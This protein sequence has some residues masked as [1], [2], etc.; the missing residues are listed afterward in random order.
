MWSRL[1]F[2]SLADFLF[3][4]FLV[5]MF[6][7]G[8]GWKALL[9]D[10]DTGWHIRTGQYILERGKVPLGDIFSFTKFGEQWFAWEW[11]SDVIFATLHQYWGLKG[12]VLLAGVVLASAA[13]LVFQHMIWRGANLFVSLLLTLLAMGAATVHYLARPHIFTLLL[14]V[15]SM[16][17]V[18]RDRRQQD[19]WVWVLVPMTIVWANLHGG[20]LSVV[21]CIGMVGAGYGIEWLFGSEESKASA[22]G[23]FLRYLGLGC[24]CAGV[25]LI[26]PYGYRVHV[27]IFHYMR[28]SWILDAVEEFQS[29]KFRNENM[30]QFELLLFVGLGLIGVLLSRRK[31]PEALL[32]LFWA[33]QS[34]TSVRHAPIFALVAAPILAAELTD[35]WNRWTA[36][37]TKAS[38]AGILRDLSNEFSR[39]PMQSS[40]WGVVLVTGLALANGQNWPADFPGIRFPIAIV[41]K[42]MEALAPLSG[43]KPRILSSDQ[44][45]DYLIYRFYPR[46][47]VFVDGRSDFYGQEYGKDYIH[48]AGGNYR[49]PQVMDKYRFDLALIPVEWPLAELLK[50]DPA[51]RVKQDDGMAILLERRS[52]LT[53]VPDSAE[54]LVRQ[55]VQQQAR[56]NQPTGP[57]RQG[58]E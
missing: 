51:W 54:S 58:V 7:A 46:V 18:E 25:T 26:N 56:L 10:G 40:I 37:K 36:N 41:D 53:K 1:L 45:G 52:P 47:R 31:F 6:V 28:S 55:T 29:P 5:W 11:G 2:P 43:P 17:I 38:I 16:W 44:W 3:S 27:H 42:H 12:V 4:A 21:A 20:F 14:I 50:R 33:Q 49:W 22:K 30:L 24:A 13:A 19:R 34:L 8:E 48:L 15:A 32:L 9:G 57:A 39:M 23:M 35:L